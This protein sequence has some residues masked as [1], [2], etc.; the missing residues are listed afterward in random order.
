M[1]KIHTIAGPVLLARIPNF[2]V[3]LD[4]KETD[5]DI[6]WFIHFS[7]YLPGVEDSLIFHEGHT[8]A[9]YT[10]PRIADNLG[11]VIHLGMVVHSSERIAMGG[12]GAFVKAILYR[13]SPTATPAEIVR[14]TYVT[15]EKDGTFRSILLGGGEKPLSFATVNEFQ[16]SAHN[17]VMFLDSV[18]RAIE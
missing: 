3:S 5:L 15:S 2:L 17:A 7:F 18:K 16:A 1:N 13:L 6:P 4:A 9:Y 11:M 8:S 10:I 14:I 12:K